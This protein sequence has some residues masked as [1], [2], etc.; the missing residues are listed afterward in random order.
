[1]LR[2]TFRECNR[3][4]M[5]SII[6]APFLLFPHCLDCHF[7]S[8]SEKLEFADAYNKP[9][10]DGKKRRGSRSGSKSADV[11]PDLVKNA[12]YIKHLFM[13]NLFFNVC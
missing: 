6:L 1:M 4:V 5:V 12:V 11:N 8:D 2:Y 13:V 3:S 9:E 10:S 7:T